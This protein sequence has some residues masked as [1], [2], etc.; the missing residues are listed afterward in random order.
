MALI[1]FLSRKA[2]ALS[3]LLFAAFTLVLSYARWRGMPLIC[4][5]F[6]RIDRSLHELPHG[7]LLNILLNALVTLGLLYSARPQHLDSSQK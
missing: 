6:G 3:T 4:G 1:L 7:L 5:C 2:V